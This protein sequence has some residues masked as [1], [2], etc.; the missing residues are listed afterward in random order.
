MT[1]YKM[2]IAKMIAVAADISEEEAFT[3][4]EFPKNPEMGDYSFPCF[5]FAKVMRKAP[6]VVAAELAEKMKPEGGIAEIAAVA[7]FLNFKLDPKKVAADTISS[8]LN[9]GGEFGR[10]N[11]GNGEMVVIDYSSVNIAK[12]FHVGHLRSTMIGESLKRMFAFMGYE[13]FGVN[14][15]G[16]YGTQFGKLIVAIKTWGDMKQ[17]EENPVPELLKLYTK[18]HREAENDESLNDQA[19]EWFAKLENGDPEAKEMWTFCVET[20]MIEFNRVYGKLGVT[21]DSFNGESFYSDKLEAVLAELREKNLVQKSQGAEVVNLDDIGLNPA[22]VTK[23]DGSTLYLTRDLAAAMYR[24][25]MYDFNQNIYVVGGTQTLHFKQVFAV[26]KK[27][28]Y[29]WVDGCVHVPF[30]QVSVEDGSLSTRHGN[31]I[32]IEDMLE[33]ARAEISR[34]IE[35]KNPELANKEEVAK[36]VGYGSVIFQELYTS[37]D[38]DYVFSVSRVT[39]FQGETGPYVQYTHARCCSLLDKA[40]EQGIASSHGLESV[41]FGILTDDASREVIRILRRFSSTIELALKNYEPHH[42][43][44]YAIDLA[45]AFNRFYHDNPILTDDA[46][47]SKTRI[48]LVKSVQTVLQTAMKLACIEAPTEM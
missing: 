45:Q 47:V 41:D 1:D 32:F 12:P 16:D 36:Q 3:G 46:E 42:V 6:P 34:I 9:Q 25:R 5:R 2:Q 11:V 23:S 37:R 48:L 10:K 8:V 26:L 14:H 35:E 7:G 20:S 29:D 4:I 15:L 19:R 17:I 33:A 22:L 31:V 28:G 44:R 24:K 30:G 13:T 38:K 27:M 43:A 18:F 21:F 40:K 39:N